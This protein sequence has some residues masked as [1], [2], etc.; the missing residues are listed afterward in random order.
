MSFEGDLLGEKI[1]H[2]LGEFSRNVRRFSLKGQLEHDRVR[3]ENLMEWPFAC[4]H[5]DHGATDT[6]DVNLDARE[7]ERER[8]HPKVTFRHT[9]GP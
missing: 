3:V 5:F 4:C 8:S 7:S 6:P 9:S 2:R 1:F